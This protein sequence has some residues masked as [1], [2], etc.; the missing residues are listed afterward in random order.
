VIQH[1]TH[2][3]RQIDT[4][5]ELHVLSG[6]VMSHTVKRDSRLLLFVQHQCNL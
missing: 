2:I 4:Q 1:L 5:M 3:D 6:H